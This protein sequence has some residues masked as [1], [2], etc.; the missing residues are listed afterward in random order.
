M[1]RLICVGDSHDF[2]F[3]KNNKY[4]DYYKNDDMI[5]IVKNIYNMDVKF[6]N[7]KFK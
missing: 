1:S 6:F 5:N 7:F 4:Q 2:G 3:K